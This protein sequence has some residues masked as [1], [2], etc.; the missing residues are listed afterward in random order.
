M[1]L[2]WPTAGPNHVPSYQASAIPFVTSS[3]TL[4]DVPSSAGGA[5]V[6]KPVEINFPYVTKFITLRNL[7]AS[8]LRLAFTFSGSYAPGETMETG[9]AKSVDGHRNYFLIPSAS[10]KKSSM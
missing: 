7:G 10:T 2:N 4:T 8:G 5:G 6:A 9:G 3:A 1:G